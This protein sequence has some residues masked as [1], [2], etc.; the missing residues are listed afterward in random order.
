MALQNRK[1]FQS[2]FE[3][4]N[5]YNLEVKKKK[6]KIISEK[7]SRKNQKISN[8]KKKVKSR[9]QYMNVMMNKK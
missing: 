5:K 7:M 1:M 4:V 6:E 8:N 9:N 3:K 2:F